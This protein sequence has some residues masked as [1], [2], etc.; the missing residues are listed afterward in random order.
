MTDARFV[1]RNRVDERRA[2]LIAAIAGAVAA[3][4]GARPTGSTAVDMAFVALGV[5]AVV[6]ASASAPWWGPAGA[7]GVAAVIAWQPALIALGAL[8]FVGGLAIGLRRRDQS[9]LRAVVGAIAMNVMV[10]SE[11]DGFF[12]LSAIIGVSAGVVLFVV[13]LRRRPSRIR[14]PAWIALGALGA[15]AAVALLGL[16][17]AGLS[18]RSDLTDAART[19]RRAIDEV[20]AGNYDHAADLFEQASN[21][22]DNADGSLGGVLAMPALLVPGVSQNVSAG[23]DLSA[24]AARST[25]QAA[26]ALRSVD[27]EQLRVVDGAIDI[28]AVR[29][30]EAPLTTV[31]QTL[32]DLRSATA[33]VRSPWLIWRLQSELDDLE[34]ELD[35]KEPGVRNAIDA[36]RLAPRM[37]GADG[38]RRYL[39]MFNSPAEARGITGFFGNYADVVISD[40]EID[41]TK[42]GR[43]S[44]LEDYVRANGAI[45]TGCPQEFVDRY[46][47]YSLA[48]IIDGAVRPRGWSNITMPAH[49]PYVAE[50]ATILYPQSGGAP[51]DGVIAMDPHVVQALMAYTGP[52]EVP[53]LGTTV[54]P[55]NAAKFILEDQYLLA[56]DSGNE[57]RIDAIDTLGEQVITALLAGALPSPSTVANDLS[58]LVGEHRLLAWTSDPDEQALFSRIGI[59]GGLPAFGDDGGFGVTVD[60]EGQNKIDV[61]LDRDT[62]VAVET[63]D[64]GGRTLVAEVTLTNDAPTGGLPK[65]VIG[66]AFDLP[67]G[68]NRYLISFYGPTVPTTVTRD[69]EPVEIETLP[70]AGWM[71]ST[72]FDHLLPGSSVTYRI[73]YPL[74]P[75]TDDV[76]SPV[77]W[78]QPSARRSP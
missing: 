78:T 37:L 53:E 19:A 64:E 49:F 3:T 27:L 29:S 68:T 21:G 72:R 41:V 38:Q 58:A 62:T 51:I 43:R 28:D 42:F 26:A 35:D 13:G 20:N 69:G 39:I 31:E 76:D 56:G 54:E 75:A 6:W 24:A 70:E 1:R 66:N 16:A 44:E 77:V 14:R 23:A 40:G 33:D 67:D 2:L 32:V 12:G 18:A 55:A 52:I 48:D 25:A 17:V 8:G 15:V 59:D 5:G 9:E 61:F 74:G 45:C 47:R 22:F 57:E 11:F 4:A 65:Y 10:R 34:T 60:N 7:S 36:V 63:D 50:V 30:V 73:D 46:G 71:A